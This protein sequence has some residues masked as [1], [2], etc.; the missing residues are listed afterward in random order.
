L[1]RAFKQLTGTLEGVTVRHIDAIS[2][3]ID[4]G[5]PN[6]RLALPQRVKAVR[7][8]DRL[9]LIQTGAEVLQFRPAT[10]P[11]AC[12]ELTITKPGR[13][14]LPSGGYISVEL[15]GTPAFSTDPRRACF[16]PGV[17]HF[18][19]L[20][21]TFRPGDRI[22][23]FG[24]SGRKKVKDVFIDRKIPMSE[25]SCIPLLFCGDDL[26][27]IAGVCV[28]EKCR[29]DSPSATTIQV[30]LHP[31]GESRQTGT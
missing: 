4:S 1:R 12:F 13:Y 9:L 6:S 20:V 14:Q 11:E 21:R 15:T 23:P 8:Y 28:S 5:R 10:M 3:L 29:I 19:W 18:P 17:I 27:W 24:M 7:E 26:I 16:D 31:E 25:R 22:T 30:T 2:E